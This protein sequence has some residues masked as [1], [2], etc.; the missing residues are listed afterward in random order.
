VQLL[1]EQ[2]K[3][4]RIAENSEKDAPEFAWDAEATKY[5]IESSPK[6]TY[7]LKTQE[8]LSVESSMVERQVRHWL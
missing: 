4:L 2:E 8:L 5:M 3:I 7:G 1:H 6:D